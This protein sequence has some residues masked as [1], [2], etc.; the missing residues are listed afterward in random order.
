MKGHIIITGTV[1]YAMR[2]REI[3]NRDGFNSRIVR[4][5]ASPTNG[6]GYGVFVQRNLEEAISLLKDNEIKI[7]GIT[8]KE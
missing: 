4:V 3:L 6:C 7:L 8:A 2:A 1:T 5:K